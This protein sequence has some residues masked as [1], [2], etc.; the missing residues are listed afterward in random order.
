MAVSTQAHDAGMGVGFNLNILQGRWPQYTEA[1]Q[2]RS[3]VPS[4]ADLA[5]WDSR[6]ARALLEYTV[7]EVPEELWL[8]PNIS[9]WQLFFFSI[10]PR[11][12]LFFLK[13]SFRLHSG[14][15]QDPHAGVLP[16]IAVS[17]LP[18]MIYYNDGM[19]WEPSA[20]SGYQE[21]GTA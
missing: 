8:V 7:N 21:K 9:E 19:D 14:H 17:T 3:E 15:C 10:P 2:H 11:F 20:K 16:W 13:L 6:N 4:P 12:F 1:I 18:C 5:P